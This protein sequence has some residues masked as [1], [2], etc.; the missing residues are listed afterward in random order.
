MLTPM[1]LMALLCAAVVVAASVRFVPEGQ[2]YTYRR[3]DGHIR[4]L[5]SGMH[6]VLPLIERVAHKIRLLGNVVDVDVAGQNATLHGQVY[7][8]VLDASRA[9][10]IIDEVGMLVRNQLPVLLDGA[11]IENATERNLQLKAELNRSLRAR[12]VLITRVQ[13]A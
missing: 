7:Y 10:T 11:A 9:D 3:M 1:L 13:L 4:T 2:A 8:Q 12:G 6:F 5:G